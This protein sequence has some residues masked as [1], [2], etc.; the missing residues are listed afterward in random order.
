MEIVKS[1]AHGEIEIKTND[2]H[3][4]TTTSNG[5]RFK[6]EGVE[7]EDLPELKEFSGEYAEVPTGIF[8]R[9]I[10]RFI[11]AVPGTG[12]SLKISARNGSAHGAWGLD[13]QHSP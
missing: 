6:L 3:Q 13:L 8:S 5:S 11:H 4:A 9:F 7:A 1:L 10:P 2:L 12:S